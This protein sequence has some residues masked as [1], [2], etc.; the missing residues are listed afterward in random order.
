MAEALR[1][2]P[3]TGL[4]ELLAALHDTPAMRAK[5]AIQ[6][7]AQGL[8]GS[9]PQGDARYALPGDDT[10]AIR[11]GEHYQLLAIE[12]MLPAFVESSPW[13]AGWSR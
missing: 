5:Q 2:T 13:F 10:A 7:P 6:R 8:S 3:A 11:C 12:G 4:S 9:L 1:K